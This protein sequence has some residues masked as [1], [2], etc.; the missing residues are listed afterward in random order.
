MESAASSLN[1]F[2][3]KSRK[4]LKLESSIIFFV[5]LPKFKKKTI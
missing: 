4:N 3:K 5:N 2:K 1:I